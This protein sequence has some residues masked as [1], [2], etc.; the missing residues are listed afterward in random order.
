MEGLGE[1]IRD[2]RNEKGISQ[3]QL[4]EK[5]GVSNAVISYWE[6]NINEPKATYI[7]LLSE[8]FNVSPSYLLGLSDI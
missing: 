4:A 6:N 1:R 3:P 2:L 7:K 5:I 8:F